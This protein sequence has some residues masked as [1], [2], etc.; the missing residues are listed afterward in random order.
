M[1]RACLFLREFGKE[2]K[3]G[4]GQK[5]NSSLY[6]LD[7]NDPYAGKF[8]KVHLSMNPSPLIKGIPGR[9]GGAVG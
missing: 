2:F 6:G 8:F 9:L 1:A 3:K 4:T 5:S 7:Y